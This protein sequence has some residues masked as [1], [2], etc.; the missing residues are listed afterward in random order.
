MTLRNALAE[1]VNS[2]AVQ[3]SETVG[4]DHVIE[5]ARKLGISSELEADPSIALGSN[6]VTLF[7]MTKAYAHLAANGMSVAPYAIRKIDTAAGK[8]IYERS[9]TNTLGSIEVLRAP[10]VAMM[11]NMMIAVT[12][13]GSGRGAQIGRPIAGKTGTTSDYRDAWF[14]GFT[15][16]LVTGVWVGNDDTQPMKKVSGATLPASIWHEY[17]MG[18]MKDL[19][20]AQ[21][22]NQTNAGTLSGGMLPWLTPQATPVPNAMGNT[23]NVPTIFVPHSISTAPLSKPATPAVA[24]VPEEEPTPEYNAPP[25]FWDKLLGE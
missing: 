18:A 23:G 9:G 5:M 10:I 4:R 7:D 19:P 8:T 22:P 1:S 6:E 3:L 17:M 13:I 11:N 21:I 15:P 2:I 25:S 14:I 16:Q 12:T 20:V 24:P